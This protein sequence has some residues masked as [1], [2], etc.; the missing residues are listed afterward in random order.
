[1]AVNRMYS[2]CDDTTN[3]IVCFEKYTTDEG[4]HTPRILPC[5]HTLCQKCIHH[6][7]KRDTLECPECRVVHAAVSDVFSFPQN[8]Y[9]C[10]NI[11]KDRVTPTAPPMP[12]PV[13]QFD[14]CVEHGRDLS[15]YCKGTK[16]QKPVCALCLINDHR[17]H[18]VIDIRDVGPDEERAKD[19]MG[20][21]GELKEHLESNKE[22]VLSIKAEL[23]EKFNNFVTTIDLKKEEQIR[24]LTER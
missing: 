8:K 4:E 10:T 22:K 14:S 16:C 2:S 12:P 15:L 6:M 13:S 24:I 1:M 18:D 7:L 5:S 9:I 23:E 11:R 19:L 20:Q 21:M 17:T 3:C